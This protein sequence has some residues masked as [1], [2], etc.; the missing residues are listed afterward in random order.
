MLSDRLRPISM[1]SLD[2]F[3]QILSLTFS[4]TSSE[5]IKKAEETL[6]AEYTNA[7][8]LNLIFGLISTISNE[9][10]CKAAILQLKSYLN[11]NK[12][13]INDQIIFYVV[14]LSSKL[15][16]DLQPMLEVVSNIF[17]Q[18]YIESGNE[19]QLIQIIQNI[20]Q[21]EFPIFGFILLNSSLFIQHRINNTDTLQQLFQNELHII[22]SCQEN[23]LMLC[24]FLH[25]F[26]SAYLKYAL[27]Y[28]KT[29]EEIYPY[30]QFTLNVIQH[31]FNFE[32]ANF[33]IIDDFLEIILNSMIMYPDNFDNAELLLNASMNFLQNSPTSN[34]LTTFFK[35]LKLLLLKDNSFQQV[36]GNLPQ[37][38]QSFILPVFALSEDD[39]FNFETDPQQFIDLVL[40]GKEDDEM[41]RSAAMNC[42]REASSSK[43]QIASIVFKIAIQNLSLHNEPWQIFSIISFFSSCSEFF[44]EETDEFNSFVK[45]IYEHIQTGNPILLASSLIFISKFPLAFSELSKNFINI[46]LEILSS[47]HSPPLFKYLSSCA[48]GR[49]LSFG[50]LEKSHLN[51]NQIEHSI[52]NLFICSQMFPT[53][54]MASAFIDFIR[55]LADDM[56]GIAEY[57]IQKLMVLFL[58]YIKEEFIEARK[59]ATI[60]AEAISEL[61]SFVNNPSVFD[62]ILSVVQQLSEDD[63]SDIYSEMYCEELIPLIDGPVKGAK[64]LTQKLLFVPHMLCTLMEKEGRDVAGSI[65]STMKAF[66]FKFLSQIDQQQINEILIAPIITLIDLMMEDFGM[67]IDDFQACLT[68]VEILFMLIPIDNDTE[69]IV[70]EKITP[71]LMENLDNFEIGSIVSVLIYRRPSFILQYDMLIEPWIDG[72]QPKIFLSS[73]KSILQESDISAFESIKEMICNTAF[74]KI[75]MLKSEDYESE[76]NDEFFNMELILQFF[77]T[78][79]K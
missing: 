9:S 13:K 41:P 54:G 44:A 31:G 30:F 46:G 10:L 61:C 63:D 66:S 79:Q 17:A 67:Y 43:N 35:I 25:Y 73:V 37:I 72:S 50:S 62:Y 70:Y 2:Q 71:A 7:N 68:F 51:Q 3:A 76:E 65:A 40:P 34:S 24:M 18:V 11:F 19:V 59:S 23:K 75:E 4:A 16:L 1:N 27:D 55:Y 38:I 39:I 53:E 36:Y 20:L 28:S 78:L 14:Q 56:S 49:I 8:F 48:V 32:N 12:E 21:S 33:D 64:A 52:Q 22:Q 15:K 69:A 26:A 58:Q 60:F 42:L 74:Q 47:D 29:P 6:R 5:E 45:F 57:C 77:Q